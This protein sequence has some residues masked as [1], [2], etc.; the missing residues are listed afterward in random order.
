MTKH[1]STNKKITLCFS[2][3]IFLMVCLL[4]Y[5]AG[6]LWRGYEIFA[7]LVMEN[8][9]AL[10]WIMHILLFGS[11][12]HYAQTDSV[13]SIGLAIFVVLLIVAIFMLNTI[14]YNIEQEISAIRKMEHIQMICH[15]G[16]CFYINNQK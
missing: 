14:S 7:P 2:A 4:G 9:T 3:G 6:D 5:I 16:E 11:L 15:N 12:L 1:I 10:I 13:S 8:T